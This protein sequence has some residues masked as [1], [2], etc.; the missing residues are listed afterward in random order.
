MTDRAAL[1]MMFAAAPWANGAVQ[2]KLEDLLL[3]S[4]HLQA[5]WDRLSESVPAFGAINTRVEVAPSSTH[6]LGLFACEHISA[7]EPVSLYPIHAVGQGSNRG[8]PCVTSGEENSAYFT[9]DE[10]SAP[11]RATPTHESLQAEWADNLWID[12]NP[13]S[14]DLPGWIAHRSNDAAAI[15]HE[16]GGGADTDKDCVG[17]AAILAYYAQCREKANAVLVPFGT[18]AP[19]MALWSIRPIAKGDEVLQIYGHDYWL[20]RQGFEVPAMT[21]AVATEMRECW[22][23]PAR[24]AVDVQQPE[25]LA[26]ELALL[27]GIMGLT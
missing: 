21:K 22:K 9:A 6:G 17:E 27:E 8:D 24:L 19:V 10:A 5:V 16:E 14:L 25:R 2:P 12:A 7:G 13:S 23:D 3:R 1:M 20:T 15:L 4:L 11:Y 26:E 18:V